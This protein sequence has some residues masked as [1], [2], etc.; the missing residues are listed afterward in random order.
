MQ[1]FSVSV[2]LDQMLKQSG[3]KSDVIKGYHL[4]TRKYTPAC[5]TAGGGIQA[6]VQSTLPAYLNKMTISL[7]N[8]NLEEQPEL[9]HVIRDILFY[10]TNDEGMSETKTY[11]HLFSAT[12]MYHLV[13]QFKSKNMFVAIKSLNDYLASLEKDE[14]LSCLSSNFIT[15]IK[16]PHSELVICKSLLKLNQHERALH[17]I[18]DCQMR[19][20]GDGREKREPL[21]IEFNKLKAKIYQKM[22]QVTH[23][24][25]RND[26]YKF[27][28]KEALEAAKKQCINVHSKSSKEFTSLLI[29]E[30]KINL[31]QNLVNEA[32]QVI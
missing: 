3:H 11:A 8:P 23:I 12:R 17:K 32:Y 9:Q 25:Q 22:S 19:L 27:N 18:K 28:A 24:Y 4:E 6:L 5:S 1:K 15:R 31:S 2:V 16:D 20:A 14:F 26:E 29:L 30:S 7:Q 13:D 10:F 21:A